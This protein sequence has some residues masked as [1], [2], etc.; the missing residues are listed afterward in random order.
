MYMYMELVIVSN[1]RYTKQPIHMSYSQISLCSFYSIFLQGELK[2]EVG[3]E[4]TVI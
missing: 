2:V 1:I 3:N 4:A